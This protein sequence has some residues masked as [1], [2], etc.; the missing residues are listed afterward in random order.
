MSFVMRSED[1]TTEIHGQN[2]DEDDYRRRV[3]MLSKYA[4]D[5]D[6]ERDHGRERECRARSD[7]VRTFSYT[8]A[9]YAHDE[10]HTLSKR[11]NERVTGE[12][13]AFYGND[14][15]QYSAIQLSD[16]KAAEY[17]FEATEDEAVLLVERLK[18]TRGME[19]IR[20]DI[21]MEEGEY[22]LLKARHYKDLAHCRIKRFEGIRRYES[23]RVMDTALV[24]CV[25]TP[26]VFRH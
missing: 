8:P 17:S 23:Q 14:G 11:R 18:G 26:G 20:G 6:E 5:R 4:Q 12:F 24:L 7:V 10:K 15:V 22:L 3:Y 9:R 2:T 19:T 21:Y 13:Q 25:A 1:N 16:E